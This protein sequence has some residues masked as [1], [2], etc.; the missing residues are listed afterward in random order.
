[1]TMSCYM[2]AGETKTA[3][4]PPGSVHSAVL[5][6]VWGYNLGK[7]FAKLGIFVPVKS[8]ESTLLVVSLQRG[9]IVGISVN[10]HAS[11][12]KRSVAQRSAAA[13]PDVA[14]D[15]LGCAPPA[16][17]LCELQHWLGAHVMI[18]M[19]ACAN[20][21]SLEN[22]SLEELDVAPRL[23]QQRRAFCFRF[24]NGV[25]QQI[26][27]FLNVAGRSGLVSPSLLEHRQPV[28]SSSWAKKEVH[29][30]VVR[31]DNG[32]RRHPLLSL[33]ASIRELLDGLSAGLPRSR[34]R[35][36]TGMRRAEA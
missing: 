3:T 31:I 27:V 36:R 14:Q 2:C 11:W 32:I 9:R 20:E 29:L 5:L 19:V 7:S 15:W 16:L 23:R 22:F 13:S 24:S 17:D 33:C 34:N 26:V 35:E 6:P 30:R 25:S 4:S 8:H 1:M 28:R 10:A 18:N 21:C 12:A